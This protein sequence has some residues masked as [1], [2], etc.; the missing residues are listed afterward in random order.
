MACQ[1][2]RQVG[3]LEGSPSI[4]ALSRV[5]LMDIDRAW[6]AARYARRPRTIHTVLATSDIHLEYK[7]R[8]SPAE[9]LGGPPRG[10]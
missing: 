8:E 3:T 2:A 7:L 5:G 1:V 4:R 6:T 10:A 9:V